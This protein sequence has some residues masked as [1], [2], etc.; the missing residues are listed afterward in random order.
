MIA[1]DAAFS[2]SVVRIADEFEALNA[3]V[4]VPADHELR[5][6]AHSAICSACDRVKAACTHGL[7]SNVELSA[8]AMKLV[9]LRKQARRRLAR[10]RAQQRRERQAALEEQVYN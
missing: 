1:I 9:E 6:K 7:F 10:E 4:N 3:L 2:P 8:Q 5:D